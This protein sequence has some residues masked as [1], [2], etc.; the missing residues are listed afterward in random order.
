MPEGAVSVVLSPEH[1]V[2]PVLVIVATGFEA[3]VI[4]YAALFELQ[5]F[6]STTL[7][8]YVPVVEAV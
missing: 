6:V 4:T 1:I 2:V 5:P 7:N 8:K 3:A